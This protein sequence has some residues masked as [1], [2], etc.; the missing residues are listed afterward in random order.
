M[1]V[2]RARDR[3]AEDHPLLAAFLERREALVLFL[4]ARTRSMPQAEDLAQD[5]YLK[6]AAMPPDGEVRAPQALLYRMAA[7]LMIDQVR[8]AQRSARRDAEWRADTRT[9]SF[10]EDVVEE[11]PADEALIA[12]ER[13]QQ[14]AEAVAALPPKMGQAFRLHKL[15]GRTQAE[16]ARIMGVSPKMIEQHMAAAMRHLIQRLRP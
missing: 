16:T 4:A 2:E 5:L 7:N 9:G 15:E 6:I 14:L 1:S 11:A 12:R 3:S 8:S 10:G 13:A